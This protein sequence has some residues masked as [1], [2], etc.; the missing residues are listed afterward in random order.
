MYVTT[1][2]MSFAKSEDELAGVLCHEVSHDIHHD[3]Y[4]NQQKQ[5][6]LQNVAGLFGAVLWNNP[7]GQMAVGLRRRRASDDVLAR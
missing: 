3:V 4:N 7:L 5:Q 1:A 6:R 2:M